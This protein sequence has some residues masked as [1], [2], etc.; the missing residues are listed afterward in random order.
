MTDKR[1]MERGMNL[2]NYFS[3]TDLPDGA[4]D[5]FEKTIRKRINEAKKDGT[6]EEYP[7]HELHIA[8]S[9]HDK[10]CNGTLVSLFGLPVRVLP[11]TEMLHSKDGYEMMTLA[12]SD[13]PFKGYGWIKKMD[14]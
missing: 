8:K 3:T 4:L 10:I 13:I 7:F 1:Q 2:P 14:L 6:W 12:I 9:F 11:E 5:S